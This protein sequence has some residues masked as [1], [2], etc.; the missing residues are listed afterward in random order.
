MIRG[1]AAPESLKRL[2]DYQY[3]LS[4]P[5]GVPVF[6]SAKELAPLP[7]FSH[8]RQFLGPG[9][10]LL[11]M[12]DVDRGIQFHL[13]FQDRSFRMATGAIRLAAM[14]GAELIPCLIRQ[15]GSWKVAIWF[16]VP[17]PHQYL[18]NSPDLQSVGAH[19]LSEFS[20]VITRYPEQCRASF[21][22]AIQPTVKSGNADGAEQLGHQR[23]QTG[24]PLVNDGRRTLTVACRR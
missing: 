18:G 15:T 16:G 9:R 4:P 1:V 21:L 7:R 6:L 10:R 24:S 2:T 20:K 17:V 14:A 3:S 11:V 22:S 5:A 8:I 13:P 12:V 19:L 23:A